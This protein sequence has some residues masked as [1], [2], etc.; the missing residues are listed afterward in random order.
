MKEF[1]S[2]M[3]MILHDESIPRHVKQDVI[4]RVQDWC[5]VEGHTQYDN[6][7]KKQHEY[8]LRVKESIK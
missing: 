5:M 7:I 3:D 1:I 6:Y 4:T 8:L 2:L